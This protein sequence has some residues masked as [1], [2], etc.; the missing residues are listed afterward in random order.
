MNPGAARRLTTGITLV[1]LTLVLAGMAMWGW[2]HVTAPFA[3]GQPSS[4]QS[5]SPA[6]I[7]TIRFLRP[8]DVQVSVYNAGRTSG[9]AGRTMNHLEAAGFQPGE[10]GNAPAGMHVRR[11]VVHT[12]KKHDPAAELVARQLGKHVRVVVTGKANGPGIDVFVGSH[13][14]K[15]ARHAPRKI[16][17]PQPV[18]QCVQVQ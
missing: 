10:V 4:S 18:R 15:L 12:T 5:C 2:Q 3:S 7:T 1:V 17:L 13:F 8:S 6:E 9:L 14:H 16:R 11:A